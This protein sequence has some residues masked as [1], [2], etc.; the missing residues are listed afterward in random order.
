M[1]PFHLVQPHVVGIEA[2]GVVDVAVGGG[3]RSQILRVVA[4][5]A[6][7]V[8]EMFYDVSTS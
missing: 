7:E 8:S 3:K 1:A 5:E 2:V 6:V 4:D